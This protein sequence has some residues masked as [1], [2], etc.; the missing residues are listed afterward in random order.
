MME[1]WNK[2]NLFL[3]IMIFCLLNIVLLFKVSLFS[4][5]FGV[6]ILIYFILSTLIMFFNLHRKEFP[7]AILISLFFSVLILIGLVYYLDISTDTIQIFYELFIIY[8]WQQ[9]TIDSSMISLFRAQE[10]EKTRI[11]TISYFSFILFLCI[12]FLVFMLF[13]SEIE[14]KGFYRDL[15]FET[16][17]ITLTASKYFIYKILLKEEKQFE[18]GEK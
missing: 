10:K 13:R 8:F 5:S 9:I 12:L 1:K 3:G 18:E 17:I 7:K 11:N 4:Y 6:V 2:V 14:A 15:Y 16:I